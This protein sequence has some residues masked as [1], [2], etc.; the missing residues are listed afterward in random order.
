M[1]RIHLFNLVVLKRHQNFQLLKVFFFCSFCLAWVHKQFN[2]K[3]HYF[4]NC[5]SSLIVMNMYVI[6]LQI[7][8]LSWEVWKETA[9]CSSWNFF[10]VCSVWAWL[11]TQ[12]KNWIGLLL[13]W[14]S[15]LIVMK[16]VL[17][18]MNWIPDIEII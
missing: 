11:N 6:K 7:H 1:L 14:N 3:W 9:I 2:F 4:V 12:L 16:I 18:R 8:V 10:F 17:Q 15:S 13:N 5:K